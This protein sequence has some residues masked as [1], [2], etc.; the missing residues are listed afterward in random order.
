MPSHSP[1]LLLKSLNQ[2]TVSVDQGLFSFNFY[3]SGPLGFKI[4]HRNFSPQVG[5]AGG[6]TQQ[7]RQ[8]RK[9][10]ARPAIPVG[11]RRANPPYGLSIRAWVVAV[12]PSREKSTDSTSNTD[13]QFRLGCIYRL[14]FSNMPGAVGSIP[15]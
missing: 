12:A 8:D 6:V 10:C 13:Y 1:D 11:L 9:T 14:T 4:R 15:P 2:F 7:P 3:D 5:L